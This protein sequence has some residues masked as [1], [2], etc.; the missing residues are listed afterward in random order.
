MKK[1]F[2]LLLMSNLLINAQNFNLANISTGEHVS[3]RALF[4]REDNLYGYFSLYDL[5]KKPNNQK[6]FEIIILDKNLNK[7]LNNNV[8]FDKY[9][10]NLIPYFNVD[11]YLVL[12]PRVSGFGMT[13]SEVKDYNYPIAKKLNVK[14]NEITNHS[15]FCFEN[16]EFIECPENKSIRD[17]KKQQKKDKKEKDFVEDNDV[18]KLKNL[19]YLVF[20]EK[21]YFKFI[22][23]NEVRYYTPE[24]ELLWAFKYNE[25]G[26]KK[27]QEYFRL[28][29][30]DDH[31]FYGF[32]TEKVK[33]EIT[34][35]LMIFDVKTGEVLK[36]K[37]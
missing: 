26:S 16:N 15:N 22:K 7:V 18:Y 33:E 23:D 4:D 9:V 30:Y 1:I 28:L 19:H 17:S 13:T 14:T 34:R 32:L 25:D 6:E 2:I 8:L 24:K 5:G 31:K 20:L 10:I 11:G 35:Y 21:D 3:F 36:K 29:H 37:K 27:T 12:S